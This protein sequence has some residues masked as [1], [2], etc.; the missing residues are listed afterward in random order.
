MQV[1]VGLTHAFTCLKN[2]LGKMTKY[3]PDIRLVSRVRWP[4]LV[5]SSCSDNFQLTHSS[6][7]LSLVSLYL[8]KISLLLFILRLFVQEPKN[9]NL[10]CWLAIAFTIISGPALTIRTTANCSPSTLV[11]EHCQ[12]QVY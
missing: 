10:I 11:A 8:A 6:Q 2:G 5:I 12:S 1:S 3:V 4:V 7:I 9:L